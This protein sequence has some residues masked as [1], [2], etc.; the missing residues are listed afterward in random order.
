[1]NVQQTLQRAI[2]SIQSGDKTTG[3]RL[4]A[5]VLQ[6][7]PQNVQAWLW[8]SAV[9][10]GNERQRDCLRRALRI[11]PQNKAA[12][13]GLARLASRQPPPTPASRPPLEPAGPPVDRQALVRDVPSLPAPAPA[14]ASGSQ[15][16]R[17]GVLGEGLW[18]ALPTPEE[19]PS[20]GAES[21]FSKN[22][23][24]LAGDAAGEEARRR[25]RGYRNIM[26]AGAMVLS[27]LCGIA[28]LIATVTTVVPRARARLEPTPEHVLYMATLWCPPCAQAHSPIVLWEKMGDGVSRGEKVGELA[29]DTPVSVLAEAWSTA[30]GRAYFKVAA[31]GQRGWVP[32]TFLKR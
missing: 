13:A 1:M 25:E 29:H 30:E 18:S 16:A 15:S 10:Q 31:Q 24:R 12:R 23:I 14:P 7:N 3:K 21:A 9:V 27:M 22:K 6:A 5:Q 2:Q 28:L 8:M 19:E 4:L 17:P 32:E 26:L 20:P 11:D